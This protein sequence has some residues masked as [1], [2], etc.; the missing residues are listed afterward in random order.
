MQNARLLDELVMTS[1]THDHKLIVDSELSVEEL[2][3][4]LHE[5]ETGTVILEPQEKLNQAIHSYSID[6][7]KLIYDDHLLIEIFANDFATSD[8]DRDS[9]ELIDMARDW[10]YYNCD[11]GIIFL[12]MEASQC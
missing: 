3:D 10:T 4:A 6:E 7:N 2:L 8:P 9:M 11:V 1:R 12:S 5:A